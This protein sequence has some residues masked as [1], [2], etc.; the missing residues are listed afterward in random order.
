[1]NTNIKDDSRGNAFRNYL[2]DLKA[3]GNNL[4]LSFNRSIITNINA[5]YVHNS[6]DFTENNKAKYYRFYAESGGPVV[7][8]LN[9]SIGN[10]DGEVL[11]LQYYQYFKLNADI[12]YYFPLSKTSLFAV[13]FNTGLAVPYGSSKTLPYEKFFFSGGSSSNRGWA[14]RRLGPGAFT[15]GQEC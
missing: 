5:S 7:N 11:G 13:R 1:M 4:Y 10:S 3:Q 9:N 14:P 12:R 15:T 6:F 8:M 2:N